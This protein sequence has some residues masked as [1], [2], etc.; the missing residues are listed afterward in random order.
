MNDEV[1]NLTIDKNSDL[2]LYLG[3]QPLH[4]EKRCYLFSDNIVFIDPR[5]DW[6][7]F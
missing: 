6:T 1:L 4:S 7:T 3:I 5:P 2:S